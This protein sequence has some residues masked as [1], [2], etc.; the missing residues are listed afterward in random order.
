MNVTGPMRFCR[1]CRRVID[2]AGDGEGN[3]L[4][5]L[6]VARR[7]GVQGSREPKP[8]VV[9]KV[10]KRRSPIRRAKSKHA[11]RSKLIATRV[12]Q[13]TDDARDH[14]PYGGRLLASKL[15]EQTIRKL[16]ALQKE[17]GG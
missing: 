8:F 5:E 6:C 3:C 16:A 10:A 9:V 1:S 14:V 4:R 12:D 2:G 7:M 15:D 17:L 11:R 13:R